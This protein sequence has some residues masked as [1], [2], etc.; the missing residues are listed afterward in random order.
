[1]GVVPSVIPKPAS[2]DVVTATVLVDGKAL[3]G[4]VGILSIVVSREINRIPSASLTIR[5]G[6]P[7]LQTFKV[8]NED[9]FLPGNKVEIK[10]GYSSDEKSV[11]KGIVVRHSIKIRSNSSCLIVE[12]RDE[13]F[14]I[15]GGEVSRVLLR[16]HDWSP[17]CGRISLRYLGRAGIAWIT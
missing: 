2:P 15:V 12:C 17:L 16:G 6:E 7:A 11:F 3:P 10:L 14:G 13:C 1:M 9:F 4:T 5:D 8:S